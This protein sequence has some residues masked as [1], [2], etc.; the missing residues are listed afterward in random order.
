VAE[1]QRVFVTGA[2][3][4]IGRAIADRYRARGA[5]VRGVDLRPDPGGKVVAGDVTEP[6]D[7]RDH[8]RGCDLVVHTAAVV[9]MRPDRGPIWRAN[10]MGTRR[11]LEAARD[12]GAARFLHLSSV[13]VFSFDFPDGVTE[14]HPLRPNGVPYVDTKVAAEQ[15][16]L[17]AHAAG[18][19]SCTVIRPG[20]VYG[21]GSRPWT[22]LAVQELARGRFVLPAMGRGVF[23]PLYIDNLVDGALLAAE[24]D[25]AAGQV[26]TLTDG[27]GV[28]TG[29]F[30]GHYG[31]LLGRRVP[32]LPTPAARGLAGAVAAAAR[33][34][35]RE[36]EINPAAASYLARRGTYSIAKARRMLRYEPAVDLAEGMRRTGDWLR[37]C[38]LVPA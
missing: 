9:S 23:S 16:V 32:V 24:S 1:P 18:E 20:D 25:Q 36:T 4:F 38:G 31:R 8:A 3:G 34:T 22:V 37:A 14:E 30:F 6:G 19:A 11:A 27:A 17:Q 2:L 33:L 26:V 5:E 15:L 10:V 29:E 28:T 12:G 35:G 21:P 7:W 13:T